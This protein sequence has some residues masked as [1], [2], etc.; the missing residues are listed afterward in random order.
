M[1][2]P[3]WWDGGEYEKAA[4][5][6]FRA[7]RANGEQFCILRRHGGQRPS[8]RSDVSVQIARL[9]DAFTTKAEQID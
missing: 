7:G 2:A 6:G 8:T 1:A 3:L 9:R 4:F 5:A